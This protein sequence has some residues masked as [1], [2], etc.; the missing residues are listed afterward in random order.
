VT[1]LSKAEIVSFM[2]AALWAILFM[3]IITTVIFGWSA[4]QLKQL[5][6]TDGDVIIAYLTAL[7]IAVPPGLVACLSIGTSISVARLLAKEVSI[8]DTGKLNAAGYVSYA[9]FDKT[10]EFYLSW[11]F[12]QSLFCHTWLH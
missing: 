5:G 2:P 6:T 11:L 4:D 9:C 3:V 12:M 7:T 1:L 8:T 10:G